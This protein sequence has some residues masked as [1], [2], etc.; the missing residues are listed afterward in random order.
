MWLLVAAIAAVTVLSDCH[1]EARFQSKKPVEEADV[2][3]GDG[4]E[5]HG[6]WDTSRQ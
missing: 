3:G 5:G 4:H 1:V 2:V 6:D